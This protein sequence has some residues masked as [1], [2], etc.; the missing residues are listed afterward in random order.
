MKVPDDLFSLC[1]LVAMR[2][3][4]LTLPRLRQWAARSQ[5][6]HE[7]QLGTIAFTAKSDQE[8]QTAISA[9]LYA[10]AD[11][12]ARDMDDFHIEERALVGVVP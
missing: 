8:A 2:A 5:Q 7:G 1:V 3:K 10:A 9:L 11:P 6:S 4:L 12:V